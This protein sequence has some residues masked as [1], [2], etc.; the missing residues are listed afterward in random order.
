MMARSIARRLPWGY[1]AYGFFMTLLFVALL[2]P[3][4]KLAYRLI[5]RLDP[6]GAMQVDFESIGL[7]L[8]IGFSLRSV[9]LAVPPQIPPTEFDRI[10]LR[11]SL[12]I[13][14][15]QPGISFGANGL[16]GR[17]D[18]SFSG[19]GSKRSFASKWTRISVAELPLPPLVAGKLKGEISGEAQVSV[20]TGS[21]PQLSGYVQVHGEKIRIEELD[22]GIIKIPS[23]D[24]GKCD[25][26][27]ALDKSK[28]DVK[29]AFLMGTDL[30]AHATGSL[31]VKSPFAGSDIQIDLFFKP[32]G[33]LV[34]R[35]APATN[36][37]RTDPEGFYKVGLEGR[38]NGLRP[39]L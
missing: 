21:P 17:L 11:P 15:L 23:A 1:V 12:N 39:R 7:A 10:V 28:A 33:D 35:L 30:A 36:L 5:A 18:G 16:G 22:T 4:E 9:T 27:I 14:K 19:R 8:P 38:L 37:L 20:Q 6:T 3:Y 25:I 24:L 26:Q 32:K 31:M 34:A 29:E 13:L 2:F